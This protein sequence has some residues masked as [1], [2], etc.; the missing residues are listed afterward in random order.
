MTPK[1]FETLTALVERA[2]EMVS[3]EELIRTFWPDTFVEESNLAQNISVLRKVLG[4]PELTWFRGEGW[5]SS[6][7]CVEPE[8]VA[9][10][11]EPPIVTCQGS[12]R[13]ATY[14]LAAGAGLG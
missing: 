1:V 7:G 9:P 8:T 5:G 14:G 13:E 4:D 11:G 3:Q 6:S 2:G 10:R 12:R